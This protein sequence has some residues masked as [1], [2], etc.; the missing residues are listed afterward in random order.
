M[1]VIEQKFFPF[2]DESN[3]RDPYWRRVSAAAAMIGARLQYPMPRCNGVGIV[4]TIKVDQHKEKFGCVRV[5]CC[6]ADH[7]LIEKANDE[8][9][10]AGKLAQERDVFLERD[11]RHYRLVYLD[12]VSLAP[13]LQVAICSGADYPELLLPTG[14][15]LELFVKQHKLYSGRW[16]Q[17]EDETVKFLRR[18]CDLLSMFGVRSVHGK[19][20]VANR[21]SPRSP[22]F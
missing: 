17:T 10:R 13:D 21:Y 2:T 22:S 1:S 16:G 8:R 5:Y 7:T 15:D 4:S 18:V 9:V 20:C 12:A 19:V 3:R 11:A 14:V 6:L